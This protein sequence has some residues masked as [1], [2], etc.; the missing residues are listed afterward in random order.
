M[1]HSGDNAAGPVIPGTQIKARAVSRSLL[2]ICLVALTT[3]PLRARIDGIAPSTR[4]DASQTVGINA[5][6]RA[7]KVD[8]SLVTVPV[9]VMDKSGKSVRNLSAADFRIFENGVEQKVD[10]LIPETEPFNVALMI[11]SSG[12]T[13][14]KSGE[15]QM[16]AMEF[17]E[18]L[19][20]QDRLMVASFDDRISFDCDFTS[21]REILRAAILKEREGKMTRLYDAI[22][23]VLR[24]RLDPIQ[25]RKAIILFTDGVDN[26]SVEANDSGTLT[27]VEKSDVI[28]YAIQYDTRKD[29]VPDRFAVP[30][31]PGFATFNDL[32]GYA[33]RYL[34]NL[35]GHSGGLLFHAESS[36]SLGEAFARVAREL[37]L[38]YTLCYYPA[39][40]KRDG[41]YR[42]LQVKVKRAGITVRARPGYREAK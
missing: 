7:I 3:S 4:R 12:S 27:Q 22:D 24:E 37:A 40:Q 6:G 41:S 17:A 23:H 19:R 21:D 29:L 20:P 38:Q 35:T 1:K 34:R 28:V 30:P 13:H 15:M 32:Y 36:G 42:R 9:M 8:V 25:G 5:G 18:A 31:P 11:D 2:L 16:A 33:V 39:N 10:R 14:F 26:E